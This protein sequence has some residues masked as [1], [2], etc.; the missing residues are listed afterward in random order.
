MSDSAQLTTP[1]D[2]VQDVHGQAEAGHHEAVL[3]PADWA[4]WGA[5]IFGVAIGLVIWFCLVLGTS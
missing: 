3:G 4:A 5:G 1:D 2:H